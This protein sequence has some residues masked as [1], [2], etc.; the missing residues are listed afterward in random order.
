MAKLVMESNDGIL[1]IYHDLTVEFEGQQRSSNGSG[2]GRP[3]SQ[4]VD[5]RLPGRRP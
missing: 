5:P 3:S 1:M 4:L 2:E